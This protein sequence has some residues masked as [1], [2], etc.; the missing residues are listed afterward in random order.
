MYKDFWE[1]YYLM[2]AY[3]SELLRVYFR[4]R[5]QGSFFLVNVQRCFAV[6]MLVVLKRLNEMLAINT[7]NIHD[8]R[9][10]TG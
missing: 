6:I 3:G 1:E 5:I 2:M 9:N 8:G 4:E 10:L 7:S